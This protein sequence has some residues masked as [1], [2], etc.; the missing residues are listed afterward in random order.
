MDKQCK[1]CSKWSPVTPVRQKT[2]QRYAD[3]KGRL[4][5]GRNCPDCH[6]EKRKSYYYAKMDGKHVAR[7]ANMKEVY[8]APGTKLRPCESC[9][10][11]NVN[12]FRCGP[13]LRNETENYGG[14]DEMVLC[15]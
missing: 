9:G 4:W 8:I 2:Y 5:S 14:C 3:S 7:L 1:M 15:G 11:K 12:Y 13:C 6:N 10:K